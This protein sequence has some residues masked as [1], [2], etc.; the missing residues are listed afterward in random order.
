MAT[1]LQRRIM[2]KERKREEE[3]KKERSRERKAS[4]V[5]I[6]ELNSVLISVFFYFFCTCGRS[7]YSLRKQTPTV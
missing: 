1:K 6:K 2:R 7:I 3:K 5:N 4:K